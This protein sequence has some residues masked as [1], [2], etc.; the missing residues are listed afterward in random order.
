MLTNYDAKAVAEV[1]GIAFLDN[2]DDRPAAAV[3]TARPVRGSKAGTRAQPSRFVIDVDHHPVRIVDMMNRRFDRL[4]K[5]KG[6]RVK[7]AS[8]MARDSATRPPS[9]AL[10]ENAVENGLPRLVLRYVAE[11]MAGNDK[12]KVASL[13]WVIVLETTLE[14]RDGQLSP[15]ES[16]RTERAA[17]LLVGPEMPVRLDPRRFRK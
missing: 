16:E 7:I 15:L 17:R 13:E 6:G 1:M 5:S 3:R 12:A 8:A 10:I 2:R 9:P 11:Q 14:R 4:G